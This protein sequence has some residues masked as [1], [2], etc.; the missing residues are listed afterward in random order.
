MH[1]SQIATRL[2]RDGLIERTP[3]EADH[4]SKRVRLTSSGH[5]RLVSAM[6]VVEAHDR[7]FFRN[8]TTP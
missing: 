5:D 8:T 7:E 6:P 3:S 1:V 4:R 2:E